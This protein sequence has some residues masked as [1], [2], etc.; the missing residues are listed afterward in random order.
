MRSIDKQPIDA[1]VQA[2]DGENKNQVSRFPDQG[3]AGV[4]GRGK[5]QDG[6]SMVLMNQHY[7]TTN[8]KM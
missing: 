8:E 7:N 3:N 5:F 2:V 4:T 6:D 1:S